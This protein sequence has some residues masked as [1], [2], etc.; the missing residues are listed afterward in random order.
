[1]NRDREFERLYNDAMA[2]GRVAAAKTVPTPMAV[3]NARGLTDGFDWNRP[4]EVVSD[5]VCGFAWVK[6][7]PA[8][9]A[10]AKWLKKTGKVRN[11]AYTGGYDIWISDYNQSMQR[12]EAH[13]EA[14]AEVLR[15]A[16]IKAYAQSRMD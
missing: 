13:A 11:L 6:V 4:Y 2:A 10:F 15:N 9:S 14:M 3:Q 12:K 5:G 8:T 7:R 16:G 1:M